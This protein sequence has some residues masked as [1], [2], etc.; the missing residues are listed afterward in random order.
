[1]TPVDSQVQTDGS[2]YL[3]LFSEDG[4]IVTLGADDLRL[5]VALLLVG[6]PA[7]LLAVERLTLLLL[8]LLLVRSEVLVVGVVG[9]YRRHLE[10]SAYEGLDR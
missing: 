9:R 6:N 2:S 8:Q 7:V 4:D 5:D 3:L 1:M 10:R